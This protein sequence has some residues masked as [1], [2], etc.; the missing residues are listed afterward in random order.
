M[1][2]R[3]PF[4]TS[5]WLVNVNTLGEQRCQLIR[6]GNDHGAEACEP[7]PIPLVVRC[8]LELLV[9]TIRLAHLRA[10]FFYSFVAHCVTVTMTSATVA[11]ASTTVAIAST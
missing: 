9:H 1:Q 5:L 4:L 10:Q 11:R 6:D 7:L 2:C 8:G 3:Q